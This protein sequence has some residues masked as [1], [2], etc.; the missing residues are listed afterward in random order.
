MSWAAKNARRKVA[1]FSSVILPAS[2]TL[3]LDAEPLTLYINVLLSHVNLRL[4]LAGKHIAL[5][6]AQFDLIPLVGGGPRAAET[7]PAGPGSSG[8][9]N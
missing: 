7:G 3:F 9:D 2:L 8:F 5:S 1:T 4:L 6:D